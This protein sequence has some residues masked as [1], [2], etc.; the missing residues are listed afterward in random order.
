MSEILD[1]NAQQGLESYSSPTVPFSILNHL[2]GGNGI[3]RLWIDQYNKMDKK[4]P[5]P[6][7]IITG[8]KE[9]NS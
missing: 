1:S 7:G 3:N 4:S 9:S 2:F 6:L 8:G 5:E